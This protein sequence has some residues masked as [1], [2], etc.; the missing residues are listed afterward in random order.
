MR[1]RNASVCDV[2]PVLG[3]ST[4]FKSVETE[5]TLVVDVVVVVISGTVSSLL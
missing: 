5:V 2:E 4:S 1:A 3:E